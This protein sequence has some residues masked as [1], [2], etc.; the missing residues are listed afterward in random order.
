MGPGDRAPTPTGRIVLDYLNGTMPAFV[1]T[2]LNIV[3]VD[4]VAR[5]HLLAAEKG[6][7]GRSYILGGENLALAGV[8]RE[9]A[10]L[11]GLPRPRVRV[12]HALALAAARVSE[13]IEGRLLRRAPRVPLEAVRM[14]TTRMAFDDSRARREL[15]YTSRPA[16]QALADSARWFLDN[17]YVKPARAARIGPLSTHNA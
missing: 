17:G 4:D 14:S 5:G 12:P 10:E 3:H 16:A 13:T 2:E 9:L 7:Q 1:D 15:G 11:T 8:L 6:A